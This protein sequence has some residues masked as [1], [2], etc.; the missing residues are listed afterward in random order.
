[1]HPHFFDAFICKFFKQHTL[2]A[3]KSGIDALVADGNLTC[4][5]KAG[6]THLP[7]HLLPCAHSLAFASSVWL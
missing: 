7:H 5:Y 3:I 2:T 4:I 1:M 6:C